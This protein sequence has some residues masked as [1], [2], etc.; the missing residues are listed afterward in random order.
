[1]SDNEWEGEWQE[2]KNEE[3]EWG[4]EWQESQGG[5]DEESAVGVAS[6]SAVDENEPNK[7]DFM[8]VK[9]FVDSVRNRKQ[10]IKDMLNEIVVI[11]ARAEKQDD[12]E[13][14][15]RELKAELK[16]EE[17]FKDGIRAYNE[18]LST[19]MKSINK[20]KDELAKEIASKKSGYQTELKDLESMVEKKQ[21]EIK[22]LQTRLKKERR[23]NRDDVER[24][25][26]DLQREISRIEK[27]ISRR[28]EDIDEIQ[29]DLSFKSDMREIER[30]QK[31]YDEKKRVLEFIEN[32]VGYEIMKVNVV[33]LISQQQPL[34]QKLAQLER[35]FQADQARGITNFGLLP[36]IFSTSNEL[37]RVE[38]L[39]KENLDKTTSMVQKLRVTRNTMENR[40]KSMKNIRDNISHRLSLV[41]I[42][43]ASNGNEFRLPDELRGEFQEKIRKLRETI[44]ENRRTIKNFK[45]V[46]VATEN[47][48]KS[49]I[50]DY[51]NVLSGRIDKEANKRILSSYGSL[52]ERLKLYDKEIARLE[53]DI[54]K[55]DKELMMSEREINKLYS[56][57]DKQCA[58]C[59]NYKFLESC[60]QCSFEMCADCRSTQS[61]CPSCSTQFVEYQVKQKEKFYDTYGKYGDVIVSAIISVS[62]DAGNRYGADSSIGTMINEMEKFVNDVNEKYQRST[63]V[64]NRFKDL[65]EIIAYMNSNPEYDL[66]PMN[67]YSSREEEELSRALQSSMIS[68]EEEVY[69]NAPVIESKAMVESKTDK[70]TMAGIVDEYMPGKFTLEDFAEMSEEELVENYQRAMQKKRIIDRIRAIQNIQDREELEMLK[71]YFLEDLEGILASIE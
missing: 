58:I 53:K 6:S 36:L 15:L 19:M 21:T 11:E 52:E 27:N 23:I 67:E 9:D 70:T 10:N 39:V 51:T 40:L 17:A 18:K 49:M 44:A 55:L 65:N 56:S 13:E 68:A 32:L 69:R 66:D 7:E 45:P 1:M 22:D 2:S 8:K 14:R 20:K 71:T 24:D 34:T 42:I 29:D 33:D 3:D 61:K 35:Q 37:A 28:R 57:D 62:P 31:S 46:D 63:G 50:E 54:R 25:I 43:S 12:D 64:R 48:M 4:G 16:A 5:W 38:N 26:L 47:T 59:A 30:D 60:Y 41:K